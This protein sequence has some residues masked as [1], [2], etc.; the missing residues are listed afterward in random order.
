MTISDCKK[1]ATL[2]SV[3]FPNWRPASEQ[4]LIASWVKIFAEDSY[5]AMEMSL[6]RYIRTNKSGFAP[7]PGQLLACWDEI[8]TEKKKDDLEKMLVN[9]DYNLQIPEK[10]VEEFVI[11]MPAKAEEQRRLIGGNKDY[12]I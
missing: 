5:E 12:G 11:G 9:R 1:L 4:L 7:S 6:V 8:C 10:K 3:N 2:I